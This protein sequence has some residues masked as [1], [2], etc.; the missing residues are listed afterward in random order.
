MKVFITDD[1]DGDVLAAGSETFSADDGTTMFTVVGLFSGLLSIV[2]VFTFATDVVG[3]ACIGKP[4][5]MPASWTA[6]QIAMEAHPTVPPTVVAWMLPALTG[7]EELPSSV[8]WVLALR[9]RP[10]LFTVPPL[11]G[12]ATAP[13]LSID[14][15]V[16]P[17]CSVFLARLLPWFVDAN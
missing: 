9:G 11:S 5:T 2:P 16:V 14:D 17:T 4:D 1:D 6:L 10:L 13:W 3:S 7:A 8:C 12:S 15:F